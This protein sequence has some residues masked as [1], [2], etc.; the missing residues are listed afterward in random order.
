LARGTEENQVTPVKTADPTII[1]TALQ[2]GKCSQN[3]A[4]PLTVTRYVIN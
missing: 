1:Q 2:K 3:R 4:A